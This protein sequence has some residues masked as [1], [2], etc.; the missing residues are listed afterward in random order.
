MPNP[1]GSD[2]HLQ[3]RM[4]PQDLM[5]PY[6]TCCAS[7]GVVPAMKPPGTETASPQMCS[8]LQQ[9]WPAVTAAVP[10]QL[11]GPSPECCASGR[12]DLLTVA[13][14]LLEGGVALLLLGTGCVQLFISLHLIGL[15][16][17]QQWYFA[18]LCLCSARETLEQGWGVQS[19]QCT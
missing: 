11:G 14:A 12:N 2:S 9:P 1:V 7:H 8:A 10:R 18:R 19:L 6:G 15:L 5:V 3:H 17:L 16:G 13:P 4:K